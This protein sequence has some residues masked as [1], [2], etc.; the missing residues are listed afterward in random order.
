M[1]LNKILDKIDLNNPRFAR[2]N[3]E[4][5]GEFNE[6]QLGPF[7]DDDVSDLIDIKP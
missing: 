6:A 5:L 7:L 3:L 4:N 2:W 1:F